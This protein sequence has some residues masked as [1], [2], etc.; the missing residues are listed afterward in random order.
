MI[1]LNHQV[2]LNNFWFIDD[3]GTKLKAIIRRLYVTS[4]TNNIYTYE[5]NTL[6]G[7]EFPTFGKYDINMQ[8]SDYMAFE[9][10]GRH[11][12]VGFSGID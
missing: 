1:G 12:Q 7:G 4:D 5:T 6:S 3:V 2:Q 8:N 10:D 9:Y 11:D